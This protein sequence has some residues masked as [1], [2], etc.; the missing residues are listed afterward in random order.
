VVVQE[1]TATQEDDKEPLIAKEKAE[2]S[3]HLHP[4]KDLSPEFG[5]DDVEDKGEEE[6][7]FGDEQETGDD[8]A[9]NIFQDMSVAMCWITNHSHQRVRSLGVQSVLGNTVSC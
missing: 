5:D 6:E 1:D 7:A 3:A 8:V 2:H 4:T 9:G